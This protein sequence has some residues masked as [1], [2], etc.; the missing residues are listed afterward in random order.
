MRSR[1]IWSV[2]VA[3]AVAPAFGDPV[4]NLNTAS[5]YGLLGGTISNTGTS[6]VTGNV[7]VGSASGTISG[8]YPTGTVVSGSVIAPGS[9][10]SNNA[11]TD[12]V[13]AL[14]AAKLLSST[15][16]FGDLSTSTTFVGNNVYDSTVTDIS[17]VSG[18]DLTFDAQNNPNE[19]FVI[20]TQ[21]AFTANG[22]LT[23]TLENQAQANHIFWIIGTNATISVGGSGPIIFDGSILAGQAFNMSAAAGGSGVLAGTIDGCVFAEDANTLS[24]TTDVNGCSGTASTNNIPEPGSSGLVS[25]GLLL[26]VLA[27]RKLRVSLSRKAGFSLWRR[28]NPLGRPRLRAQEWCRSKTRCVPAGSARASQAY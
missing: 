17:T 5:S 7:G 25:F 12:F 6:V 13:N 28:Q 1:V 14:D 23:F 2:M 20:R 16:T 15:A 26:G 11:Y 10:G 3:V 21:G 9:L 24:G 27:W 19:V 4:V 22:A 18:I 8:F